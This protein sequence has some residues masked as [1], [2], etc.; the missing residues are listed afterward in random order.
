[1]DVE[2]KDKGDLHL[3]PEGHTKYASLKRRKTEENLTKAQRL[4][5]K[6][7]IYQNVKRVFEG[8]MENGEGGEQHAE[9]D[10]ISEEDKKERQ[11]RRRRLL[12]QFRAYTV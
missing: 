2:E 7:S 8:I 1:M 11:T 5:T 3:I 10:G 9:E 12:K 4:S 6:N